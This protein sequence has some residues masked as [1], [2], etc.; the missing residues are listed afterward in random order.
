MA[1][2][3]SVL[4][5]EG[6]S[7]EQIQHRLADLPFIRKN[8]RSNLMFGLFQNHLGASL[9]ALGIYVAAWGVGLVRGGSWAAHLSPPKGL[10]PVA[11]DALYARLLALNELDAPAHI[12]QAENKDLVAEWRLEEARWLAILERAGLKIAHH[13]RLRFDPDIHRVRT[14]DSHYRISLRQGVAHVS[15]TFAFFHGITFFE[16]ESGRQYGLLYRDGGWGIKEAYNY[17][18]SISELKQPLVQVILSSGWEY[19]PVVFFARCL[20][21]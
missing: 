17:Q 18:Y 3:R 6:E 7:D 5:I 20:T 16:F 15:G 12:R 1:V 21:G 11:A 13:V 9:A 4:R 10:K 14:V 2:G 19:R 8:P